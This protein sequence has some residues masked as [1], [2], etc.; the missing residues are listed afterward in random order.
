MKIDWCYLTLRNGKLYDEEGYLYCQ[1]IFKSL[2]A[3]NK[4]LE[5]N[6]C[7]ATII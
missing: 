7:R 5:D 6:D 1:E 2:D 3:A 4:Y